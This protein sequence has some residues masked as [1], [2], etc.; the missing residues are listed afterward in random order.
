MKPKRKRAKSNDVPVV[1]LPDHLGMCE[2]VA[3][4]C[5]DMARLRMSLR[6][7]DEAEKYAEL[8]RLAI[9]ILAGLRGMIKGL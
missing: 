8:A 4:H 3:E 6:S 9:V 1:Q 2:S 5:L 7:V